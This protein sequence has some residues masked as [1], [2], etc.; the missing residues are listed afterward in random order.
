MTRVALGLLT[1]LVISSSAAIAASRTLQISPAPSGTMTD[2][3]QGRWTSVHT[4]G[5]G[6]N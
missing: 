6:G 4:S 1:L 3:G 5:G 2:E